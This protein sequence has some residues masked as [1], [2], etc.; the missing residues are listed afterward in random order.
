VE[1]H[2]T[3]L[4]LGGSEEDSVLCPL[5]GTGKLVQHRGVVLCTNRDFRLDVGIEGIG[6]PELKAKLALSLDE[7]CQGE[8]NSVPYF[9]Q[10][11]VG[12]VNAL[13]LKCESCDC[14]EV[15]V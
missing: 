13:V 1:A 3:Q 12:G 6:L 9:T 14:F 10:C 8:C 2:F 4:A 7:H 15:I 5:C 11:S